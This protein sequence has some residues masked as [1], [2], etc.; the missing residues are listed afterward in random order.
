M[1]IADLEHRI[2]F[3]VENYQMTENQAEKAIKH[4][5]MIRTRYLD[6]FSEREDHDDPRLY[7]L[8]I[9]MNHV[10]MEQAEDIV[11]RLVR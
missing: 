1:L 7:T 11:S 3:L 4:A 8:V 10:N 9:N 6:C 5:D 2:K